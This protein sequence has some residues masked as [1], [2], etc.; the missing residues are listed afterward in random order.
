M[1]KP[2][3][4]V[5]SITRNGDELWYARIDGRRVYCGKNEEGFNL[6]TVARKKYDV[7]RV[8]EGYARAGVK[9]AKSKFRTFKQLAN[10]YTENKAVQRKKS[11]QRMAIAAGHLLNYFKS[12]P[13]NR[14]EGDEQDEYREHRKEQGVMDSTVDYEIEIL[15]SMY[16]LALKRK[17]IHADTLPGEFVQLN[18]KNPRPIVSEK[19]YHDLREHTDSDFRDVLVCAWETPMRSGE[20]CNLRAGKVKLDVQHISGAVVD[21]I[22]L[23]IFETKTKARRIIPISTELKAVLKTRMKGLDPD[24]YVFTYTRA[25]RARKY[26]PQTLWNRMV[27]ACEKAGIPHGDKILNEQGERIGLTFHCF[28]HTRI[29]RWVAEGH[30]DEIIRRASGHD[31]L[32]AYKDYVKLDPAA[33]CRLVHKRYTNGIQAPET[34]DSKAC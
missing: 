18:E 24:E 5:T 13:L 4:G 7:R 8:E 9:K 31:S 11:Y 1:T 17:K 12:T 16:R 26:T 29:S 28:R 27:K 20:I 34:L 14:I 25:G 6:A 10:W 2:I 15:R 3:T 19:A 22:D 33:I 30:S 32:K 21:Y 23:G